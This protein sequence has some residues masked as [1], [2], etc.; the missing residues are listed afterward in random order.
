MNADGNFSPSELE[1]MSIHQPVAS[2]NSLLQNNV[3]EEIDPDQ[4]KNVKSEKY[5]LQVSAL[6]N[7]IFLSAGVMYLT[8]SIWDMIIQATPVI[9]DDITVNLPKSYN[10]ISNLAPTTYLINSTFDVHLAKCIMT[11]RK[12]ERR[13]RRGPCSM[14][15]SSRKESSDIMVDDWL[16]DPSETTSDDSRLESQ[17][18][19]NGF[20]KIRKYA[21][22]RRELSASLTFFIAALL[23]T[24]P[25]F[26]PWFGVDDNVLLDMYDMAS[27]HVYLLSSIIAII[28]DFQDWNTLGNIRTNPDALETLGNTLFFVGSL[29]DVILFDYSF[30]DG[31]VGWPILSSS[32][33]C[34]DAL[35]Y[36]NSDWLSLKY[37]R[38]RNTD[39][40][41][42]FQL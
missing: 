15:C 30:D 34:I 9:N 20:Y 11:K 27:V 24:F 16:E 3:S 1:I 40:N 22:H 14:I 42:V 26:L 37:L 13:D 19:K 28:G 35:L 29:V 12:H 32:L 25:V 36:L 10:F 6:S 23:S 17:R 18:R 39:C 38:E 4:N 31:N 21:V 5:I 2:R 7:I 41:E 8:V 33:W